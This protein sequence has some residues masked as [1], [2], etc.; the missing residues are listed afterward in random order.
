[1]TARQK[2]QAA[3]TAL[4]LDQPFFGA[5]A[6][7]LKIVE[8]PG[9]GTAWTDGVSLGYDPDFVMRLTHDEVVAVICHEVMHAANGHMW[10]RDGREHKRWN[11]ACDFAVN[12]IIQEAGF[13]LPA[14]CLRDQQYDH[15][16]AEWIYARL[17][18]QPQGG[19]GKG[20]GKGGGKGQGKGQANV[21]DASGASQGDQGK[22]P[23]AGA[24]DV[25]D[26]PAEDADGASEADWQ[27]AVQQAAAAAKGRGKL[28]ASIAR[29]AEEAAE[30]RVDW[31]SVVMRWA[32]EIA[33]GDYSWRR[34][35]Q[36][37]LAQGLYLPSLYS[38]ETGPIGVLVD[39]SGSIDNVLLGQFQAALQAAVDQIH[40]R[41]VYVGFADAKLHRMDVFERDDA[42][43]FKPIGGGGTDFRP[44]LAAMEA[45][46]EPPVGVIYITDLD[47]SMPDRPPAFPVLWASTQKRDVPFGEVVCVE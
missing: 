45:L 34:P 16:S 32:Q 7:R 8:A 18:N 37:Y 3:R 26:A 25:R 41:R 30:S 38:E 19:A 1:M 39:T 2:I 21:P 6:L 20:Q 13:R 12:P 15:R 44:G 10:R 5:L 27:Q 22:A 35:N 14:G 24:C 9:C 47:G 28:P 4:V 17:P 40:P 36:R 23:G 42:I 46:E 43:E 31:K 11:V 33:N 29:L